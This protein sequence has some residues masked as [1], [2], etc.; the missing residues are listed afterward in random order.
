MD[1]PPVPGELL[2]DIFL[3]LS[4]PADLVRASAA[5]VSFRRLVADRSFLRQYRR[6]HAPPLLGF[7]VGRSFFQ[8]AVAPHPSAPAASAV[9]VA[10]DFSFAFL[11]G[12]SSWLIKDVRD[13]RA[14]LYRMRREKG[15]EIVACDPLHRR[16]LLLPPIPDEVFTSVE[17]EEWHTFLAPPADRGGKEEAA[18]ETA[19]RVIWMARRGDE[20][21][22]LVFSSSTGQWQAGPTHSW[23]EFI[24]RLVESDRECYL[25]P[26]LLGAGDAFAQLFDPCWSEARTAPHRTA[27]L[28]PV[29]RFVFLLACFLKQ[30]IACT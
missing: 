14:L 20:L 21:V 6:L 1:W 3:R 30:L 12:S 28:F 25:V 11:P 27:V 17:E 23:R 18:E 7:L 15:I 8:P 26:S 9:A 2:V 10:A 24:F 22:A 13:G 19:F 5:C 4:D 16:Y 29:V